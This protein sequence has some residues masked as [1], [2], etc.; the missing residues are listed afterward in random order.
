[1]T[2]CHHCSS[3]ATRLTQMGLGRD[4]HKI[5]NKVTETI[6]SK[7]R[8]IVCVWGACLAHVTGKHWCEGR[9][10]CFCCS[11]TWHRRRP[12]KRDQH[13]KGLAMDPKVAVGICRTSDARGRNPPLL[14]LRTCHL[15]H[16]SRHVRKCCLRLVA[17]R[18]LSV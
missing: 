11:T 12:A 4:T 16:F 17:V 6:W 5:A 18:T 3:T 14:F 7:C 13:Q 8:C 15:P 10:W 2:D 1:M 9:G